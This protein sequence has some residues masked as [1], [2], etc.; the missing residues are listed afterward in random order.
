[1]LNQDS[2]NNKINTLSSGVFTVLISVSYKTSMWNIPEC[3]IMLLMYKIVI[4][5][6][7]NL[8]LLFTKM[9]HSR[10]CDSPLWHTPV[11]KKYIIIYY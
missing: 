11:E 5:P 4:M 3:S 8:N 10:T 9:K 6:Y 1:M 2:N 7:P